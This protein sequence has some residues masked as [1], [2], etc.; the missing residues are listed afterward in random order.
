[1]VVG[2]LNAIR[3]AILEAKA[4]PPLV[5]DTDGVLALPISA[6]GMKPVAGRDSEVIEVRCKVNM[7]QS[8]YRPLNKVRWQA[9]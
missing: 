5:V 1:V 9:S 8:S 4:N 6:Q 2:Y 3:V 7:L